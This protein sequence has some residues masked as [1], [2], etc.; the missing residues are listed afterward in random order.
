M[1]NTLIDSHYKQLVELITVESIICCLFQPALGCCALQT[2]VQ[3][4]FLRFLTPKRWKK[5]KKLENWCKFFSK[6]AGF[7]SLHQNACRCFYTQGP[8]VILFYS[9]LYVKTCSRD[10]KCFFSGNKILDQHSSANQQKHFLLNFA[11]NFLLFSAF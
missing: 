8:K 7:L 1:L 3:I 11:T 2:L 4:C 5:R 10:W 6:K 9:P